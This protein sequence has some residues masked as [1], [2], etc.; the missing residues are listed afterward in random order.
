VRGAYISRKVWVS[1]LPEFLIGV[2]QFPDE[3]QGPMTCS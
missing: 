2:V 1:S 3:P